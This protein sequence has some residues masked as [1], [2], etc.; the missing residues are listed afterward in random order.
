[1]NSIDF[2]KRFH[3]GRAW[4]LTSIE[5]SQKGIETRAFPVGPNQA[6]DAQEFVDDWNGKRNLYFSVAEVIEVEDKK[7]D[8]ANVAAVHW[9]HVDIDA[10]GREDLIDELDRIKKLTTT[11][12]PEGVPKPTC[13]VYSGGGRQ[14]F[15]RLDQPIPVQGNP[16]AAEMAAA[17]NRQLELLFGG[18]SC[19]N[20]D[21]IMRLPGTQNIP[22]ARKV[23]KGRVQVEAKV[24]SFTK[25]DYA[26]SD[27]SPAAS[28]GA[29]AGT[30][31][32][33]DI[34]TNVARL[35]TVDDLDEWGVA[36]RVKV[37]I[38]QG[39]DPDTPKDGDNTRSAWLFDCVCQLVRSN[40]P[41]KIVFSVITDPG[42]KISESVLEASN[43]HR[44]AIKQIRSAKEVAESE[45]LH[46][47]NTRFAVI[48]NIGGAC[49]IIEEVY[50]AALDRER[51]VKQSFSDFRN[52]FM[53]Q[54]EMTTNAKGE[55]RP[56][57]VG[58]WW[59]EHPRRR[60]FDRLVFEPGREIEGAY[61]LWRG[62]GF[63]A[64]PGPNHESFLA[65]I[66]E[67]VCQSNEIHYEYLLNW[68]AR[69]IQ[70]PAQPGHTAIVMR[71]RPG[72]GKGFLAKHFGKLFKRHFLHVSNAAHLT[73]NFNAHLRDAIIVFGDEAFYAGNSVHEGVLKTLITEETLLVEAKGVDAEACPN[74]THL[75]LASNSD[76]VV[77]V[78]AG[79]RR[80]FVVDVSEKY[81]QNREHFGKIAHDLESGGYEALLH[82]LLHR[83]ISEY[84]VEKIPTSLALQS[85]VS[86][87][88][89]VHEDWWQQCLENGR[90]GGAVWDNMELR[91]LN[92]LVE[93]EYLQFIAKLSARPYGPTKL[94]IFLGR[95]LP[96][97]WPKRARSREDGAMR[98]ARDL[99]SITDARN[100][101][102]RLMRIQI[103]WGDVNLMENEDDLPF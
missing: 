54:F 12:L 2:L 23:A 1:M 3:P 7:A 26:L 56:M 17:Y 20:V 84:N 36:D 95:V 21:R 42:F 77:P 71:G 5:A 58:K 24:V 37:I 90:I 59:L 30:A 22:N 98:P 51:L 16:E 101:W 49:R 82:Y 66:R 48:G 74:F 96:E 29:D 55:P 62:F 102:C 18:D 57:P 64:I 28:V 27:F 15:W 93:D 46:K 33:I 13:I 75:I 80:Y 72:T 8:T 45:W 50:D 40:V 83:D 44:Y 69:A 52:R 31:D 85:Q 87:S 35:A 99:P 100:E 43:P 14:V 10:D 70:T 11:G 92:H 25:K 94:G 78:G 88:M 61:N 97:G 34:P 86:A 89:S 32:D 79:D 68:M 53:N 6:A 65:H 103:D 9:L 73:G 91:T 41:D 81:A 63:N 60:Q 38:V 67:E 39:F 4:V 76:W 47:L 19:H